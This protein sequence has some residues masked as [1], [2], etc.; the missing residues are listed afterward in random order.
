[1][2]L[3]LLVP[4][5]ASKS[6]TTMHYQNIHELHWLRVPEL[7]RFRLCVLAYRCLT[8]PRRHITLTAFV[9]PPMLTVVAVYALPS[10]TR[11]S[12][13]RRTVQHSATVLSQ[14]L[15]QEREMACLPQSEPLRHWRRFVRNWRPFSSGRVFSDLHRPVAHH[16][17]HSIQQWWANSKSN[18]RPQILNLWT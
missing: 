1:M 17:W 7:I 12:W 18:V 10:R 6:S 9:E 11:W 5:T 3:L 8:A 13:H 14:W 4:V 15:H 16:S 2:T